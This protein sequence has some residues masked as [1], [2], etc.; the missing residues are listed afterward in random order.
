MRVSLYEVRQLITINPSWRASTDKI[1]MMMVYL[2]ALMEGVLAAACLIEN[3]KDSKEGRLDMAISNRLTHPAFQIF[4]DMTG[5]GNIGRTCI[6]LETR[7]YAGMRIF[8]RAV[9]KAPKQ[10]R[11][12]EKRGN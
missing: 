10:T 5:F 9:H 1:R 12:K 6:V 2:L 4:S 8:A 7:G 3:E 11:K